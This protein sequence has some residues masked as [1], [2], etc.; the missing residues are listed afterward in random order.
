MHDMSFTEIEPAAAMDKKQEFNNVGRARANSD[1]QFYQ[2]NSKLVEHD[3][4]RT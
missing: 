4:K 1:E 2:S 3:K